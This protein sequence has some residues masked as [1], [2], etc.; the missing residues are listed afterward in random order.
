[1]IM[2]VSI[3]FTVSIVCLLRYEVCPDFRGKWSE[4]LKSVNKNSHYQ[5]INKHKI[6]KVLKY[7]PMKHI[8]SV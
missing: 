2:R 6:D 5:K 7:N 3:L 1:M 4:I 8:G